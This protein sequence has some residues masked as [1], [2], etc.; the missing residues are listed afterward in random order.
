[1]GYLRVH[2][3]DLMLVLIGICLIL[4]IMAFMT[5]SLSH[6]RKALLVSIEL[7]AMFLL[8][9]DRFSYIY[10]GNISSTGYW[11]VRISNFM[12]F[13]LMLFLEAAFN[14]YLIDLYTAEGGLDKIPR[15]LV[16]GLVI[17]G[18]GVALVIISQFTGL[19]YSFD[20]YNRYQRSGLGFYICYTIPFFLLLLYLSVIIQYY[21]RLSRNI[22]LSLII[23]T[24]VPIVASVV[25]VFLYGLSLNN[26]AV[27]AVVVLLHIFALRDMNDAIA[28]ANS[29]EIE[30]LK[31]EH[32]EMQELFEQTAEA[33]A[34]AIDAKD[35]Y[36]H[37]HSSRVADYSRKI[38]E[39]AGL[40]EDMCDEVYYSA[41]LHDVGK[42]GVPDNIINKDGK[43]TDEEF[44]EI[45]KHPTIGNQI[46]SRI[47]RSPYLSIGAHH[48][49]ERYDGKGYPD[50]LMG[51]DIP[52]IAR[53]IAVADAYD[54]MTSKRSYRDPIPQHEVREEIVK[55][56]GTQFDPK[57]A[58]LML[59]LIDRD[60]EYEMQERGEIRELAGKNTL[61]CR[62]YKEDI[63]EGMLLNS[64][65]TRITLK[66]KSDEN[67]KGEQYIPSLII[68]DSLDG[69]FH[70][71]EKKVRDML[72]LEY[73]EIRF[74][75]RVISHGARKIESELTGFA[76]T[77]TAALKDAYSKG[78]KY[79]IEAVRYRDHI[80][81]SISNSFGEV[82]VT[83]ALADVARFAY[84]SLTG[85][86][87]NIW[88]V[89]VDKDT[90]EIGAD[91]IPRIADEISYINVPAGDIP[92]V[93]VEGWCA[94]L[95][96]SVPIIDGM[97][98]SFH[99]MS[100]PTARL[101]W[102]C[103]YIKL[104]ASET[105]RLDDPGC[106]DLVLIRFDG[107]DWESDENVDNKILVQKDE[108]F[109]D[110]DSWRELNR[111]GMDCD[112][113]ITQNDN[114]I[115][116][117]TVNGGINIIS[118]TTITGGPCKVYAALTGDQVALTNIRISKWR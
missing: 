72:Y 35:K 88:N 104:F 1:M 47:N 4:A 70:R 112:I 96:E 60:E 6:R 103:P 19:Y 29:L 59:H 73:A 108:N 65:I 93:Q 12:V 83:I 92:N 51:D 16:A 40:D 90:T 10:R 62:E 36:T 13:F 78:L 89:T 11:M 27:V 56:A 66:T 45:K 34:S 113:Y 39:L 9:F 41:L 23:F 105:G 116:V 98:I 17:A 58:K 87:C 76:S 55:G 44:A 49:H 102:H 97:K 33:L 53:I 67:H 18:I 75:G 28:R 54:A 107:E 109:R 43:L 20:E 15:R 100:L 2:Q 69:R 68:F 24:I 26:L 7:G 82:K 118:T 85:E 110:W 86:H 25:Q 48:H 21:G 99:T 38:A 77:D 57:F 32:K 64:N 3:L 22:S 91:Y 61:N 74:D 46:L 80:Q 84:V 5:K 117:K 42:I 95:S 79:E 101:I 114:V 30:Y 111:K 52:E 8:V 50:R 14:A 63:S 106:R 31:N 115:T 37:G 71:S 94:A 81:I